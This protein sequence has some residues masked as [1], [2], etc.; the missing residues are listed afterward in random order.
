MHLV[1]TWTNGHYGLDHCE[2]KVVGDA[3]WN[4]PTVKGMVQLM[5]TVFACTSKTSTASTAFAASTA[6][7]ASTASTASTAFAASSQSNKLVR[8]GQSGGIPTP[9]V[10]SI[11]LILRRSVGQ[12]QSDGWRD[13]IQTSSPAD[14]AMD[15]RMRYCSALD[16]FGPYAKDA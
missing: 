3:P 1:R 10:P 11:P 2:F 8:S 12:G 4:A 9:A 13:W 6:F 14:S 5:F 16:G 15:Y 7:T